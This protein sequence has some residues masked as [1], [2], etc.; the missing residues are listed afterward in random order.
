MRAKLL[1]F[2]KPLNHKMQN[3]ALMHIAFPPH[4]F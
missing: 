1:G 2:V 4:V 3:D